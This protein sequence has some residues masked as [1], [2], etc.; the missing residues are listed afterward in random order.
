MPARAAGPVAASTVMSGSSESP[1]R[2]GSACAAVAKVAA[3]TAARRSFMVGSSIDQFDG[4]QGL[5]APDGE[6]H[7]RKEDESETGG[8]DAD[9]GKRCDRPRRCH[10]VQEA[11]QHHVRGKTASTEPPL[12][13]HLPCPPPA[14][15]WLGTL[16]WKRQGMRSP[17]PERNFASTRPEYC[18]PEPKSG[19]DAWVNRSL[20][21]RSH[22]FHKGSSSAVAI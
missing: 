16:R 6:E 22:S 2:S 20:P 4:M 19:I 7:Q 21:P 1:S 13:S 11:A 10:C 18:A 12:T 15:P 3:A 14:M 8:D 9:R 5:Q 17:S